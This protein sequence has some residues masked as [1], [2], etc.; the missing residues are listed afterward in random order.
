[1][2]TRPILTVLAAIA[3]VITLVAGCAT[4]KG[5]EQPGFAFGCPVGEQK[6]SS[7]NDLV[8]VKTASEGRRT[9]IQTTEMRCT[10]TGDGVTR[11]TTYRSPG[12]PPR[13][14]SSPLPATR[15]LLPSRTPGGTFTR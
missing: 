6:V 8:R 3:S 7:M 1:M 5:F 15:I 9:T 13:G 2:K 14:P 12:G 11:V 4:K 10:K